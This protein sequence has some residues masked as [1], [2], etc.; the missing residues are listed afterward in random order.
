MLGALDK[1]HRGEIDGTDSPGVILVV[2]D[3]TSNYLLLCSLPRNDEK[4]RP[5]G[6]I[7]MAP[8]SLPHWYLCRIS[9]MVKAK[10]DKNSLVG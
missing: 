7:P 5:G 6:N 2:R 9:K 4:E 10:E 1:R 8:G 3:G